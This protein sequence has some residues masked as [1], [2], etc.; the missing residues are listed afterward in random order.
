MTWRRD[1]AR[2]VGYT[3]SLALQRA[4]AYNLPASFYSSAA[5]PFT[6][7]LGVVNGANFYAFN[8]PFFNGISNKSEAYAQGYAGIHSRGG[9]GQYAELGFTLYGSNNTYNIAA[10]M[11]GSASYRQPILGPS[12]ALQVSAD[13]IF[14]S[15][16]APY[17]TYGA[18][19]GA[20]LA[21]G[22]FGVRSAIPYGPATLRVMLVRSL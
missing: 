2:G 16:S 17:V 1:P 13:N 8:A 21:N 18:G 20:P 6:T 10:F 19:I 15:N 22:Q 12:L 14:N 9:F 3:F 7:N 11:I 4:F 5:G